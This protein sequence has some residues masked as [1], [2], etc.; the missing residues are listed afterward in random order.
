MAAIPGGPVK[1]EIIIVAVGVGIVL[2]VVAL[3]MGALQKIGF[4]FDNREE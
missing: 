3:I 2:V 1:P 4:W